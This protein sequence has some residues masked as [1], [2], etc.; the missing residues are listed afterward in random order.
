[1]KSLVRQR[2]FRSLRWAPGA[3]AVA[4]GVFAVILIAIKRQ[5]A[6]DTSTPTATAVG[7]AS[8]SPS[9]PDDRASDGEAGGQGQESTGSRGGEGNGGE[10]VGADGQAEEVDDEEEY[11]VLTQAEVCRVLT[12][13]K[14]DR[15]NFN[16]TVPTPA[17]GLSPYSSTSIV[18]RF[19]AVDKS[20]L[21]CQIMTHEELSTGA[22]FN[23]ESY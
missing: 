21:T 17:L 6:D 1:M 12:G 8:A 22:V 9:E 10:S 4:A 19:T 15:A 7:E 3:V 5:A 18:A 14:R 11:V 16:G 20:V 23:V 2:S 13:A